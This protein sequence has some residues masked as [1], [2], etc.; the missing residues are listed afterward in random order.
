MT[1]TGVDV[2][3][4]Q[5]SFLDEA[6]SLT[7]RMATTFGRLFDRDR[8]FWL[9]VHCSLLLLRLHVSGYDEQEAKTVFLESLFCFHLMTSISIEDGAD[10]EQTGSET[11][12]ER[13]ACKLTIVA[14][15]S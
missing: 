5:I 8:Q 1:Q 2:D 6:V 14:F 11:G 3:S 9:W 12:M 4:L 13:K 7:H 10:R 15:F